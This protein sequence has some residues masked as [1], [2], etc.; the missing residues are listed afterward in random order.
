MISKPQMPDCAGTSFTNVIYTK[1]PAFSSRN[2]PQSGAGGGYRG[3]PFSERLGHEQKGSRAKSR[4]QRP[5]RIRCPRKN[6]RISRRLV[7]L[8]G[9]GHFTFSFHDLLESMSQVEI[10]HRL[11]FFLRPL[12]FYI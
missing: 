2:I 3:P 1:L 11:E 4:F 12:A 7:F 8:T 5:G 10:L 9:P 6:H